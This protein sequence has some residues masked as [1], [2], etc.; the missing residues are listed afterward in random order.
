[1]SLENEIH[2]GQTP[3]F[4]KTSAGT[5]AYWVIL[6]V[7]VVPA[8]TVAGY[9][10]GYPHL[11]MFIENNRPATI[12]AV[13]T[14]TDT[15]AIV[16]TEEIIEPV[17][18]EIIVENEE[19]HVVEEE[20]KQQPPSS[21]QESSASVQT[22][23]ASVQAPSS[24]AS[25]KGYYIIVGSFREKNNADR[26]VNNAKKGIELEVIYFEKL[27]LHCVSAGRYDNSRQAHNDLN[28]IRNIDGCGKAWV[29]E[30][31]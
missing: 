23:S 25:N 21:V 30:N 26:F 4:S 2:S 22:S 3:Q 16:I 29:Y 31:R 6:I 20:T 9:F 14:S 17:A 12:I 15:T 19:P 8:F 1:M 11:Q 28:S 18:E 7:I 24:S 5:I 13:P 10:I 27:G